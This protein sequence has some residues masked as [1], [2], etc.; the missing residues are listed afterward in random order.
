MEVRPLSCSQELMLGFGAEDGFSPATWNHQILMD[1]IDYEDAHLLDTLRALWLR[2]EILRSRIDVRHGRHCQVVAPP[3]EALPHR[4]VG[5]GDPAVI[6][7]QELA[8]PFD[9]RGGP[10]FRNVAIPLPGGSVRLVLTVN[11]LISD[12]ES[13][14]MLAEELSAHYEHA[15]NAPS[16][17]PAPHQYG[18]FARWQ[19]AELARYIRNPDDAQA[20]RDHEAAVAALGAVHGAEARGPVLHT[21]PI[22]EEIELRFTRRDSTV[23]TEY[24]RE[25]GATTN[26]LILAA[27]CTALSARPDLGLGVL[28]GEKT[29][30]SPYRFAH[31][32][33]PFSDLWPIDRRASGAREFAISLA[34]I[35]RQILRA[36][37]G[38]LPFHV[39]LTRTP[40]LMR[41]L[42]HPAGGRWVF[43]QYFAD[44]AWRGDQHTRIGRVDFP[45]SFGRQSQIFGLH[46]QVRHG[47]AGL[48]ARL[49]HRLDSLNRHDAGVLVDRIRNVISH[50]TGR[51]L[52][53]PTI[54]LVPAQ[55]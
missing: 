40:W 42:L 5:P 13:E 20:W 4:L 3:G 46:M 25:H 53:L 31:T 38:A 36:I 28:I 9:L 55:T 41:E 1:V 22:Q 52:E 23:L 11:H 33:G 18:E 37:D 26:A 39:L 6:A 43:Y 21:D 49:C 24:C 50:A 14:V 48:S 34:D 17:E 7:A 35:Q 47:S 8:A 19:R 30:R 12:R 27:L 15:G 2:H 32:L 10:L 51:Q 16:R 54:S 29:V 44:P 45:D